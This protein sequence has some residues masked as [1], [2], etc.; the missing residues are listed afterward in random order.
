M[1][2]LSTPSRLAASVAA[3]LLATSL[4]GCQGVATGRAPRAQ[5]AFPSAASAGDVLTRAQI[6]MIRA[7]TMEELLAGRFRGVSL[8]RRGGELTLSIRGAGDPLL[9]LNGL[10]TLGFGLL[11]SLNPN[12]IETIEVIKGPDTSIYGTDGGN[13]VVRIST[14]IR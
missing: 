6:S 2:P 8:V 10:P 12:D 7:N 11:W 1:L 14:R 13:G 9:V 5:P 4:T 3:F